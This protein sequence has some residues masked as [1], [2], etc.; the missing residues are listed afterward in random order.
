MNEAHRQDG[1]PRE[2][3]APATTECPGLEDFSYK[4]AEVHCRIGRRL[5]REPA[6]GLN[7]AH[8]PFSRY[9]SGMGDNPSEAVDHAWTV[10]PGGTLLF[11][12]SARTIMVTVLPALP[13]TVR[14]G[15]KASIST[16]QRP[17]QRQGREHQVV[18]I[19]GRWRRLWGG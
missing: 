1:M 15:A 9:E 13:V 3:V 18:D 8:P 10:E 2:R 7:A 14:A 11:S 17:R 4:G 5:K 6:A 12:A 19:A 16:S